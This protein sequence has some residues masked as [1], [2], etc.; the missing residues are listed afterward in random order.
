[1]LLEN[2]Y[3]QLISQERV[4]EKGVFHVRLLPECAIYQ[5]HFPGNPICPG[6]CQIEMIKECAMLLTGRDLQI[7]T[8]TQCRLTALASPSVCPELD[9]E[10]QASSVEKGFLVRA[11]ISDAKQKYVDFKGELIVQKA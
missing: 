4:G 1:M 10:V 9:I 2:R 5:G 7:R 11:T 8:V 3:Y 6:I